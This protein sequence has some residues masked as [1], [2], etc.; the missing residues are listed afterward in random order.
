M[1][2]LQAPQRHHDQESIS[3]AEHSRIAGPALQRKDFHEARPQRSLQPDSDEGRRRMENRVSNTLRTLR[4]LSYALRTHQR[5]SDMPGT[6]QQRHPETPGHHSNC[7]PRRH[8]HL[9][10]IR[11][12]TRTPRQR[13][14]RLPQQNTP[15]TQYQEMRV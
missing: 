1:C 13:N 9:L 6:Y 3:T 7:L 14:T 5:T 2:G 10:R 4:I 11:Q 15:E 8:P 12:R